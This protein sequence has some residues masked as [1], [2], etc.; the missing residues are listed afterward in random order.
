[1][2]SSCDVIGGPDDMQLVQAGLGLLGC[3]VGSASCDES[4]QG[5]DESPEVLAYLSAY[6]IDTFEVT[7]HDFNTFLDS[8]GGPTASCG[9]S[10]FGPC[11]VLDGSEWSALV[12]Q[13]PWYPAS[14]VTW[15][16]ASDYCASKSKRLCT[17][18][19]WERAARHDGGIWPWGNSP[20]PS[21]ACTQ[22]SHGGV[23]GDGPSVV[24]SHPE[25]V[26][27]VQAHDMAGNVAEWTADFYAPD[28]YQ[29]YV[30]ASALA[31]QPI[32]P[33]VGTG[34]HVIRGGSFASL[35][36]DLTSTSRSFA[37]SDLSGIPTTS[38]SPDALGSDEIGFRCCVDVDSPIA[39]Q[40]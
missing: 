17:E 2:E 19:E 22:A 31:Y 15:V 13:G 38:T 28:I 5:E 25:G 33:G 30:N 3:S 1:V 9:S 34:V 39:P 20:A 18:A 29:S 12:N 23:C 36:P 10:E 35:E 21:T 8:I 7:I 6:A 37:S 40:E 27:T 24:G 16:G 26:S 32:G 14:H 4:L 11:V